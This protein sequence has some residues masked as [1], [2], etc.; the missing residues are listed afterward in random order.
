MVETLT[1][2]IGALS[3]GVFSQVAIFGT[4]I[5][6]VVLLLAGAML[7]FTVWLGAPQLRGVGI[8][9][10]R[11]V[12]VVLRGLRDRCLGNG[13]APALRAWA[14]C[15]GF[16]SEVGLYCSLKKNDSSSW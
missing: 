9:L 1:D 10:R 8:G 15:C 16:C 11:D 7:F 6:L 3:A 14:R 12:G 2:G 5:E 4:D 13:G